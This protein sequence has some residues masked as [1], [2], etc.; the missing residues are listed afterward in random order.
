MSR[1]R[2]TATIVIWWSAS[3]AFIV[4]Q[5]GNIDHLEKAPKPPDTVQSH[6][7][8]FPLLS[9]CEHTDSCLDNQPV[10]PAPHHKQTDTALESFP[11][12]HGHLCL[13]I[14][15]TLHKQRVTSCLWNTATHLIKCTRKL[16]LYLSVLHDVFYTFIHAWIRRLGFHSK[17][18][19]QPAGRWYA[20]AVYAFVCLPTPCLVDERGQV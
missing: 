16:L 15:I 9:F 17:D 11:N 20:D 2:S 14:H 12:L 8:I 19:P 5:L 7:C 1:A 13:W 6:Y 3:L 18:S 10:F 4:S